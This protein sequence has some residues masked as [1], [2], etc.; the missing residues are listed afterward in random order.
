MNLMLPKVMMKELYLIVLVIL[1]LASCKRGSIDNSMNDADGYYMEFKTISNED[2]WLRNPAPKSSLA[3]RLTDAYNAAVVMSSIMTDFDLGLRFNTPDEVIE[4]VKT[5]DVTMVSEPEVQDSLNAYKKEM[6]YM[7]TVDPDSVDMNIH[8]PWKAYY[9]LFAYLS[10][11][12]NIDTFGQIDKERIW[13]EYDHCPSVPEWESLIEKRGNSDMVEELKT[14]YHQA[15]DF[16]ARCIYAIELCHAYEAYIYSPK[17]DKEYF[18]N[19]AMALMQSLM[20]EGQY[21]IYL[22]E[23][24]QKWRVLYQSTKGASRD[25]EIPNWIYND[26]RKKCCNITLSYIEEHP[27]DM[28]AINQYLLMACKENILRYGEYDYGNQYALELYYLFP[29]KFGEE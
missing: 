5:I 12:Y 2:L 19:P 28:Q 6:L 23:L 4:A 17:A 29:E 26:Y 16:D 1:T 14:K 9:D 8:N 13:D 7:L 11:K 20:E 27:Q 25:S 3:Q 24:W 15:K 10:E 18:E 21:S 22:Y